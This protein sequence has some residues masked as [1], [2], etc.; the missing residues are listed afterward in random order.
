MVATSFRS[1]N[2]VDLKAR[3]RWRCVWLA[4]LLLL[5][6]AVLMLGLLFKYAPSRRQP[7]LWRVL[8]GASVTAV[9]L[10]LVTVGYGIYFVSFSSYSSLYG[11][12]GTPLSIDT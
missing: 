2:S 6:I 1:R 11:A 8:I 12:L 9:S 7:A 5:S 3:R 10:V 4:S